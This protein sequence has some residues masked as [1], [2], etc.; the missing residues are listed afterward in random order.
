MKNDSCIRRNGRLGYVD[1]FLI[2]TAVKCLIGPTRLFTLIFQ[3]FFKLK[4]INSN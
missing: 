4:K 1:Q 2:S 3:F